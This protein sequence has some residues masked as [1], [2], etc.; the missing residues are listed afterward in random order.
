ML[1]VPTVKLP[2]IPTPSIGALLKEP[3]FL[4]GLVIKTALIISFVPYSYRFQY[5]P[6][7]QESVYNFSLDPWSSFFNQYGDGVAFP[8]GGILFL[9]HFPGV[10]LGT[11]LSEPLGAK[12]LPHLG[13]HLTN[14]FFDILLL[15]GLQK[16]FAC[17]IRPL[18][19]C[20]WLSP[21]VLF[22]TYWN[23]SLYV[24]P[25]LLAVSSLALLKSSRPFLAGLVGMGAGGGKLAA[26][27][28][29][30]F[31]I[32]YLLQNPSKQKQI[33]SYCRGATLG[34]IAVALPFILSPVFRGGWEVAIIT[35]PIASLKISGIN[36]AH[37]FPILFVT[38]LYLSWKVKHQDS[39]LLLTLST[40]PLLFSLTFAP[41]SPNYLLWI[42]PALVSLQVISS[43]LST[44]FITITSSVLVGMNILTLKGPSSPIIGVDLSTPFIET[45]T[46]SSFFSLGVTLCSTLVAILLIKSLFTIYARCRTN[47]NKEPIVLG[48]C[49]DS[50]GGKDTIE[51]ALEGLFEQSQI[52]SLSGEGYHK[53]NRDANIWNSRTEI[54]P[55]CNNLPRFSKD[56][57][58]LI[59]GN[60]SLG[61][62]NRIVMISSLHSL[63]IPELKRHFDLSI[64]LKIDEEL[65]R[66]ILLEKERKNNG[67]Q[68]NR[69]NLFNTFKRINLESQKYLSPQAQDADL[70]FEII[71]SNREELSHSLREEDFVIQV[72]MRRGFNYERLLSSLIGVC[73]LHVHIQFGEE[74]GSVLLTI[75]GTCTSEDIEAAAKESIQA[76]EDLVS[77]TP[78]FSDGMTGVMQLITLNQIYDFMLT[79]SNYG[80]QLANC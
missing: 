70:L 64:Y 73:D 36:G 24:A 42:V 22:G 33:S 47:L 34:A 49:A 41:L 16:L 30:A 68:N 76:L 51:R 79:R 63:L 25:L 72:R 54:D 53:W 46:T 19:F 21:L 11:L 61:S 9:L 2:E 17:R 14:L 55:N 58:E 1:R 78:K 59:Q 45:V 31:V 44:F 77:G 26:A 69:S 20:Y 52:K 67:Y 7:L 3:M 10:L 18:L 4:F 37:L 5:V 13:I 48:L 23:G 74:N 56:A 60:N 65:K 12:F 27:L 66:H 80:D 15:V 57:V 40:L 29:V 38:S 50:N 6:F 75:E 43:N 35:D 39:H 8:F 28:P 62:T 32:L 71:P